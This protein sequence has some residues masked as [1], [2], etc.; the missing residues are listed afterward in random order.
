[1]AAADTLY[2]SVLQASAVVFYI[3]ASKY[4]HQTRPH[5]FF[6]SSIRWTWP[7]CRSSFQRWPSGTR[8][9]PAPARIRTVSPAVWAP[10][11]SW[12]TGWQRPAWTDRASC[13]AIFFL[14]YLLFIL[15]CRKRQ[16]RAK[17]DLVPQELGIHLGPLPFQERA[18]PS[19]RQRLT[20]G[21]ECRNVH[22]FPW[23]LQRS[24][25]EALNLSFF[26]SN[27]NFHSSA[28][29]NSNGPENDFL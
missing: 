16:V 3:S 29:L 8:V 21:P 7:L 15:R 23:W 13:C 25:P 4:R 2:S 11:A 5:V 19:E 28:A 22:Q 6:F 20:S 14:I 24:L 10:W 17:A 27:S 1:M 26:T 12:I 9:R 18:P